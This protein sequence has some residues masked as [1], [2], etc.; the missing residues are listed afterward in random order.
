[1]AVVAATAVV[2]ETSQNLPVCYGYFLLI[3]FYLFFSFVFRTCAYV[4]SEEMLRP[5]TEIG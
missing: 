3:C 4:Y 2:V 1:M 5:T